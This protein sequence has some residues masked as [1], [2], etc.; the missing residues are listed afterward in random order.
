MAA[1]TSPIKK[2]NFLTK[3]ALATQES[4]IRL[5]NAAVRD[6]ESTVNL[7]IG[8]SYLPTVLS[9][10][11]LKEVLSQTI[12]GDFLGPYTGVAGLP[13]FKDAVK[14]R[15]AKLY[16]EDYKNADAIP[17]NGSQQSMLT[18]ALGF[19]DPDD[20]K[21]NELLV[22]TPNFPNASG[23]FELT[24]RD[25]RYVQAPKENGFM[26][27]G[28]WLREHV[29]R[30]TKAVL[31]TIPNN[32]AG[33]STNE[34]QA[35]DIANAV[36]ELVEKHPNLMFFFDNAYA[37][38]EAKGAVSPIKF[39]SDEAKDRSIISETFSKQFGN[40][41]ARLGWI[42]GNPELLK[43][44]DGIIAKTTNNIQAF[45]QLLAVKAMDKLDKYPQISEAIANEYE[46]R[47]GYVLGAIDQVKGKL[48]QSASSTN[49]LP[50]GM[51][52]FSPSPLNDIAIPNAIKNEMSPVNRNKQVGTEGFIKS[53]GD[54]ADVLAY[55]SNIKV[56]GLKAPL[57]DV[58][59]VEGD[60]FNMT[61]EKDGVG[62]PDMFIRMAAN[63]DP[64]QLAQ[65]AL[66]MWVV[67]EQ[68]RAEQA[69]LA[70]DKNAD[71]SKVTIAPEKVEQ[72]N[73]WYSSQLQKEKERLHGINE[74]IAGNAAPEVKDF[75]K[76]LYDNDYRAQQ[77]EAVLASLE[78]KVAALPEKT[79]AGSVKAGEGS[80]QGR[81]GKA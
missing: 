32:P 48:G 28:N 12:R 42:V 10:N 16:G 45:S 5:R 46:Y 43:E 19:L 73:L 17:Q 53:S 62:N 51:F 25:V 24:G 80:A 15:A 77:R 66:S 79:W 47:V 39:L 33:G 38:M 81:N 20:K 74:N 14:T 9:D 55:A 44:L 35:K 40:S 22:P 4:G 71:A 65:A 60:G 36:N 34:Q 50:G 69:A 78:D 76:R 3:S 41:N 7:S 31:I 49:N 13:A 29:D 70:N 52:A 57:K 37:G 11:E 54:V 61:K 68:S 63:R 67:T 18:L 58:V 1:F 23:S 2:E 27:T 72:M 8:I 64:I 26:P 59:V 56:P 30:F 75:Y 21:C 6:K